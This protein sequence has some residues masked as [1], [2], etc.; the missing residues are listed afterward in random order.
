MDAS[1]FLVGV[2]AVAAIIGANMVLISWVR[3]DIQSF[4]H[5][6][7]GWREERDRTSGKRRR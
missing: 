7:R 3:S 1:L 4:T 5:E 2:G 6:I